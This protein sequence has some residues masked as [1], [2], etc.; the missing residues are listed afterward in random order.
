MLE[1][2]VQGGLHAKVG[3][4]GRLWT[5]GEVEEGSEVC[6]GEVEEF[7]HLVTQT[8]KA[9]GLGIWPCSLAQTAAGR[10]VSLYG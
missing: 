9:G 3:R 6:E 10:P 4:V 5:H 1:V 2:P 8:R 7:F